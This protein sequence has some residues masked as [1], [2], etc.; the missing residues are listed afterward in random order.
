[1]ITILVLMFN[2]KKVTNSENHVNVD[3]SRAQIAA[4][5][6]NDYNEPMMLTVDG[7]GVIEVVDEQRPQPPPPPPPPSTP[8]S[9]DDSG[10]SSRLNQTHG[11]QFKAWID[12]KSNELFE[13]TRNYSGFQLLNHTYNTRLTLDAK[14]SWINFTE[15]IMNI[16]NS[17]SEVLY[18]KTVVVKNLSDLVEKSFNEYA[19]DS[20][21]V[22]NSTM[23]VYYDAKSPYTFC[24]VAES[25]KNRGKNKEDTST[26]TSNP[27]TTTTTTTTT[28]TTTTTTSSS[29]Q[30]AARIKKK[31]HKRNVDNYQLYNANLQFT[32]NPY[33]KFKSDVSVI[34][35][36]D[37]AYFNSIH[38]RLPPST[39]PADQTW[40]I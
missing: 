6:L 26:T 39:G 14:F 27:I 37:L 17:I 38:D 2:C 36:T 30:N 12:A 20:D 9:L 32:L 4:R 3:L 13:L 16:S 28:S 29:T 40:V 15:M 35:M 23:H 8:P 18:N 24:D 5:P 19:N 33:H 21:R 11:G 22:V 34:N 1:M 25:Y 7:D 31:V 10:A